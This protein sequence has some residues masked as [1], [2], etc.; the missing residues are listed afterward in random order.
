MTK[1]TGQTVRRFLGTDLDTFVG[2]M[3]RTRHMCH[4]VYARPAR[5]VKRERGELVVLVEEG[6]VK[7]FL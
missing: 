7:S 6:K 3:L 2:E 4:F 1:R 5:R